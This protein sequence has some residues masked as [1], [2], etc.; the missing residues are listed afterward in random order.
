MP[1][2]FAVLVNVAAKPGQQL[3]ADPQG[4]ARPKAPGVVANVPAKPAPRPAANGQGQG[5]AKALAIAANG[6]AKPAG[7]P[8]TNPQGQLN[9]VQPL[10]GNQ[11][12]PAAIKGAN[13][14]GA[15]RAMHVADI[16]RKSPVG[17][18]PTMVPSEVLEL[19]AEG[20]LRRRRNFFLLRILLF[21]A[22]PT[23]IMAGYVY[24]YATPRYV[25][26]F[27]IVYHSNDPQM[28][29][30]SLTGLL[31]TGTV[32]MNRVI[33]A[34]IA[35][36][37]ILDVL[38]KKF[39][40]RKKFGNPNIDWWDRLPA[41][42]T[43]ERF[44]S[45]FQQRVATY[46]NS[47]GYLVVDI[48]AF[49]PTD[50][51]ELATAIAKASDDMV[52]AV[53]DREKQDLVAFTESEMHRYEKEYDT[54]TDNI[55]KFREKYYDYDF[56]GAV[57]YLTGV[58]GALQ[59]NLAEAQSN[60]HTAEGFLGETAPSVIVLKS[61][62]AAIESQIAAE[63]EG[64]ASPAHR[65]PDV[66]SVAGVPPNAIASSNP[67]VRSDEPYSK[68]MAAYVA[69]QQDQDFAKATLTNARHNYEAARLDAARKSAYVFS[70]IPPSLPQY[71]T[72]PDPKRYILTTI[73]LS[74]IAYSCLSLLIGMF[75]DN[76]GRARA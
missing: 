26:E 48:S 61:R 25:S 3:P 45:Y 63:H 67:A 32:D 55:T 52:S 10:S 74:L 69:L 33:G 64:L 13:I 22:L 12:N 44:L 70:F 57:T 19:E 40:L 11:I 37:A 8:A 30:S 73:I 5:T 51:K 43:R 21:V 56:S 66:N 75:G 1:K 4:Q 39:D 31:G 41:N 18:L 24:W 29:A 58:V 76:V 35:S 38:D 16:G 72:D 49:S 46:E 14:G 60:L 17:W 28:Q 50:A 71:P 59:T 42:A 9:R 23:L 68:I 20:L 15:G 7:P 27:Q 2:A 62:I 53:T 47:G 65:Q 36:D 34:Y 6:P 54:A